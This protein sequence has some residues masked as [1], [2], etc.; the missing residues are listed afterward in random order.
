M[1][2]ATTDI[3]NDMSKCCTRKRNISVANL[4]LPIQTV[5]LLMENKTNP[6]II[7]QTQTGW[8]YVVMINM[9]IVQRQ[10]L[11]TPTLCGGSTTES[12]IT[13]LYF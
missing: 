13:F 9:L 4:M 2:L 5:A 12:N 10:Q 3:V 7:I 1:S 6:P 11:N 8:A